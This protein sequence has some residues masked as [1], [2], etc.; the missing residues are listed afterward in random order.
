MTQLGSN[1]NS[2]F[3]M[4]DPVPNR[5]KG[6]SFSHN[7]ADQSFFVKGSDSK[8]TSSETYEHVGGEDDIFIINT[9]GG[10]YQLHRKTLKDTLL[11]LKK[12]AHI[13]VKHLS[14]ENNE[15]FKSIVEALR[16]LHGSQALYDIVLAD[17][18]GIFL[19]IKD[20]RPGTVSAFFIGC[21]NEDKFPGPLGCNPKCTA[22]LPPSDGT[23]GYAA[24]DDLILIYSD[25]LFNSLNE[26]QS[27]HAYIYIGDIKFQGFT[28]ENISQLKAAGVE[29]ASIIFGNQDGSYREVTSALTL[30]QLPQKPKKDETP[31]PKT[32]NQPTTTDSSNNQNNQNNSNNGNGAGI[33]VAIIII[34][35]IILALVVLYRG[36]RQYQI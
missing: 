15:S 17:I 33:V 1:I 18:R 2:P 28:P 24:C 23:P 3:F 8:D 32:D 30:S 4:D 31:V 21:F 19:D 36:N 29:N 13:S 22:S 10:S 25:G 11:E 26:R 34:A 6:N 14:P 16:L 20:I 5:T 35:I 9:P 12:Q 27:S 7:I